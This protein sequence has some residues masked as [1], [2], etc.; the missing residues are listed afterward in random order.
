MEI[1]RTT[2]SKLFFV[3]GGGA[4][5]NFTAMCGHGDPVISLHLF[6]SDTDTV[7]DLGV[8]LPA[9]IAPD[10]FGMALGYVEAVHGTDAG[11]KFLD[12]ML[13]R[14]D[15]SLTALSERRASYE[16]ARP[17]CCTAAVFTHG[18]DHTCGR[19]S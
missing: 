13:A 10:L 14:K 3:T 17:A 19:T 12:T 16:A 2:P 6:S 7:D 8:F 1:V 4:A 18:A 9:C 5:L 11:R 15:K